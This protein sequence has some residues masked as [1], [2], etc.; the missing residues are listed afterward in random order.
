MLFSYLISGNMQPENKLN[1]K[2]VA[3]TSS[4]DI[5]QHIHQQPHSIVWILEPRNQF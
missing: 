2:S 5:N 3:L 1:K 4:T